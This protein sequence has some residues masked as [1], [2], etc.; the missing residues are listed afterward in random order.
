MKIVGLMLARNEDWIIGVSVRI[1][2]R[3][4]DELVVL[5]HACTDR[6][7]EMVQKITSDGGKVHVIE[8][9][10][11]DKWDEMVLR[12]QTLLKAREL[13]ASHVAIVDADEF[14]TGNLLDKVRSYF[15]KLRPGQCLELPMV[16]AWGKLRQYRDDN[17]VWSRAF[18]TLGF[19]D[20]PDLTWRPA[21]DGYQHHNRPPYGISAERARPLA[22]KKLGG[23]V[24]AQ[25]ANKRRL[26]AKHVL[27]RMVDH[28]RWP[29]RESV[30]HLNWKYDQ[31]LDENGMRLTEVPAD[32]LVSY[33]AI[34]EDYYDPESPPWHEE[35]VRRLLKVHGREKF[36]GLDLKGF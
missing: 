31:A 19:A 7:K 14:I 11:G 8:W 29:D 18:I 2:L 6:T 4:C 9:A 36:A 15:Q 22:D 1:A 24:H 5:L 34:I 13:K 23:V 21:G 20:R 32:W 12:Q 17:S 33:S 10:D 28:L 27:Y 35:E 25:F 30:S 16:P 3:W 26:L